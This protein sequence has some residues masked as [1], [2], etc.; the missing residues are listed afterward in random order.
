MLTLLNFVVTISLQSLFNYM[1][2]TKRPTKRQLQRVRKCNRRILSLLPEGD[3]MR[4]TYET[5]DKY[6]TDRIKNYGKFFTNPYSAPNRSF[7]LNSDTSLELGEYGI[8]DR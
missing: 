2:V 7:K 5:M 1:T 4:G 8:K 3:S 6:I